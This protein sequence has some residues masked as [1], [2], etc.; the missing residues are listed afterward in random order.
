MACGSTSSSNSAAGDSTDATSSNGGSKN[1]T[2]TETAQPVKVS[3]RLQW[4]PSGN[5]APFYLA[6]DRGYYEQAGLDVEILDGNGSSNTVRTVGNA[7]DTFGFADMS[8]MA[9]AAGKGVPIKAV[10]GIMQRNV[11]GVFSDQSLNITTPEDLVGHTLLHTPESVETI[12]LPAFFKLTG[13]D[14]NQVQ[15]RSV[16]AASKVTDYVAG[17]A[18]MMSTDVPYGLPTINP[19][20]SSNTMMFADYGLVMPSFGI[21]TTNDYL[22]Q[23]PEVVRKF[24]QASLKGLQEALDDPA[25][26]IEAMAKYREGFDKENMRQQWELYRDYLQ[27]ERTK[28]QPLGVQSAEDWQ[29]ALE[30]LKDYAGHEGSMD[31]NDYFTNEYIH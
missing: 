21:F 7:Q 13:I 16:G 17:K 4:V 31:P 20:R 9:L 3:L 24:V 30:I 25:A 14:G 11:F 10:A 29:D 27:T 8:V 5:Q 6:F 12:L 15:L 1:E 18:D 28:G 19:K 23:N 22:E 2:I 26:A